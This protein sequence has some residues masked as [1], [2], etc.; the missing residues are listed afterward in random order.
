M[1]AEVLAMMAIETCSNWK[2]Y[3]GMAIGKN[4]LVW[5]LE[6]TFWY[7]SWTG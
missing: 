4:V 1:T 2:R 7:D 5:Q 3:F 6:K